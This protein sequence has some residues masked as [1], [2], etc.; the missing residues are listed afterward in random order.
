MTHRFFI[1]ATWLTP[2]TVTFHDETARQ[3]QIVLRMRPG[4]EIIVLDNSGLEWQVRLTELRKNEIQGQLVSQ[5]PAQAEPSL[6][7]T[8]YQGTL[9]A[10]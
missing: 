7:L 4:D 8:L 10:D 6:N 2:P 9:K 5:Q 3:I 1:P